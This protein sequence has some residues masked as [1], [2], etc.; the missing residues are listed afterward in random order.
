MIDHIMSAL[1]HLFWGFVVIKSAWYLHVGLSNIGQGLG[2]GLLKGAR[3][4][5]SK[6]PTDA[7]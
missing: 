3:V 6:E 2:E 1:V 4:M 5:K 7:R